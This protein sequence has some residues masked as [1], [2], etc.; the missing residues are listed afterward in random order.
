MS[1]SK[2]G[3]RQRLRNKFTENPSAL[4][5][6]ELLELMPVPPPPEPPAPRG[7]C[8][9]LLFFRNWNWREGSLELSGP[10]APPAVLGKRHLGSV[11]P[12]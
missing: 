4:N 10:L 1:D 8:R 12:Y 2:S 11:P 9:P 6:T 7:Y 3:H 5:E